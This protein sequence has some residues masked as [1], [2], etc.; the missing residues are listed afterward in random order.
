M[1]NISDI[2]A[3]ILAGGLGTRLRSVVSDRPKVM[4]TINGRPFLSYLFDQIENAGVSHVVLSV[5]YLG[6]MIESQFGNN[7]HNLDIEYSRENHPLGTGGAIRLAFPLVRSEVVLV[8]NGDSY[9]HADL[10]SFYRSHGAGGTQ[11]SILLTQVEDIARYGQIEI[12]SHNLV[13][14]FSEK[15]ASHGPG[16]INAGIYLINRFLLATIPQFQALSLERETFPEWISHGIQGIVL[17]EKFI[18]IGTPESYAEAEIFF[19]V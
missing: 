2:S 14:R 5:G 18:D 12:D 4:A 9:C 13:S 15:G 6:N 7:Y 1:K 8:M 16:L 17:G 11:A 19:E 10:Q 3:I